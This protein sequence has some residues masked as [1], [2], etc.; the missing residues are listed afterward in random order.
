MAAT[1]RREFLTTVAGTLVT[2]PLASLGADDARPQRWEREVGITTGSFARQLAT[3]REAFQLPELLHVVRNELD[4]KVVDVYTPSLTSF[5]PAYLDRVRRTAEQVGCVLTNLKLNQPDLDLGSADPAVRGKPLAEYK[6]GIDAAARLGMRWARPLPA[7]S[8]PDLKVVASAY[9]ELAD[10]AAE[11]QVQLLVENFG[12]MQADADSVVR[13]IEAVGRNVAASPDTGNS[14]D[15]DV[16][17][18]GL[19]KTF[20]HAVTCDFKAR[21]L[22][23]DGDHTLY[24]L[25]RCFSIGWDAGFRGPWCLEHSHPDDRVLYRELRLLRDRLR[26]WMAERG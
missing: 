13:L 9:R 11:R 19:A 10:Y 26:R 22:N 20:P 14:V 4:L 15:N 1:T 3:D 21:D 5:E 6:R 2:V 12:W 8:R 18:A 17:Y 16:R 23:A 25:K 7:R 24:D